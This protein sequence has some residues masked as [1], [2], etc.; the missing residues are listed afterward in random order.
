[1]LLKLIHVW[2][3]EILSDWL[4]FPLAC[5]LVIFLNIFLFSGHTGYSK[6]ILYNTLLNHRISV[7]PGSLVSSKKSLVGE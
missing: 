4:L 5:P 7:A 6:F 3:L 2:A 1:M